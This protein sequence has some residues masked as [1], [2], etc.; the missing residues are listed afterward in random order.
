MPASI[1]D[2]SLAGRIAAAE[3]WAN[4]PDRVAATASARKTFLERFERQ[5]DP[6]GTLNPAERAKRAE[7]ARRAY[8]LRLAKLSAESRRRKAAA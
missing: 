7:H 1:R 4:E 6:D 5:V 2:R 8:F 3:R